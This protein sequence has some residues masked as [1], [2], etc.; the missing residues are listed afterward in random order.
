MDRNFFVRYRTTVLEPT[1]VIVSVF[2]PFTRQHEYVIAYKQSRRKDDDIA[3]TSA[4]FRT[5]LEGSLRIN[6]SINHIKHAN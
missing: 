6:T 2:V 5:N 1:D 3:I 4:C